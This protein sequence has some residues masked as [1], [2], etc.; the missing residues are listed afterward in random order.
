MNQFEIL[1]IILVE[2]DRQFPNQV[3]DQASMDALTVFVNAF[4][5]ANQ[6]A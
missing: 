4:L 5:S 3:I 6:N 2:L 1:Q